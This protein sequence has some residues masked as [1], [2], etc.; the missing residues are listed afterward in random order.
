MTDKRK[1][2]D[3]QVETPEFLPAITPRTRHI[4]PDG[5]STKLPSKRKPPARKPGDPK[6]P[7]SGRKKGTIQRTQ[8]QLY[9]AINRELR[10]RGLLNHREDFCPV[11]LLAVVA[12]WAFLGENW[13]LAVVAAKE[14]AKYLR[15]QLAAV[16][17]AATIKEEVKVAMSQIG[18]KFDDLMRAGRVIDGDATEV[19]DL[20]SED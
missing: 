15:P 7:G 2:G 14:A 4:G 6:V 9:E 13:D 5:A 18:Q 11:V 19:E 17:I 3:Y 1:T 16:K 20:K 12:Q 10:M 8:E